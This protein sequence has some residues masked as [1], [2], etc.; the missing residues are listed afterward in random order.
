MAEGSRTGLTAEERFKLTRLMTRYADGDRSA[1]EPIFQILWPQV[2]TLTR[3][4]LRNGADAEDAAQGALLKV[5]SRIVDFDRS[6]DGLAWALGIAAYE[7]RTLLQKAKR[8]RE[9]FEAPLR[10]SD[11]AELS[12]EDLLIERDTRVLVASIIGSLQPQDR[13]IIA[14]MLQ[15]S[16]EHAGPLTTAARK[17][18]QR[19]LER[20]RSAWSRMR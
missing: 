18:K 10:E 9:E 14:G 7:A 11:D 3:H 13:V 19:V 2:L 4:M 16:D 5:F 17:R 15:P 6:R 20:I 8:R 1:F 12:A